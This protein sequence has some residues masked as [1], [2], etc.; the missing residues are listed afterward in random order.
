MSDDLRR[1]YLIETP[2]PE[3]L[4]PSLTNGS[5]HC[6][7][8]DKNAHDDEVQYG[9]AY[10]LARSLTSNLV[11]RHDQGDGD[12]SFLVPVGHERASRI[13]GLCTALERVLHCYDKILVAH[14]DDLIGLGLLTSLVRIVEVFL[15]YDNSCVARDVALSKTSR[16]L[17]LV[18][19]NAVDF[20]REIVSVL[21]SLMCADI[22]SDARIDA[23]CAVAS[24]MAHPRSSG[25]PHLKKELIKAAPFVIST[26]STAS[27][28]PPAEQL[29]DVSRALLQIARSSRTCLLRISSRRDTVVNMVQLMQIRATQSDVLRL[30]ALLLNCDATAKNLWSSSPSTGLLVLQA[31]AKLARTDHVQDPNKDLAISILMSVLNSDG[32]TFHHK[33]IVNHALIG[34]AHAEPNAQL[35]T[36]VASGICRYLLKKKDKVDEESKILYPTILDFLQFPINS[37]RME[38]L[39][40]LDACTSSKEAAAVLMAEY[41][42]VDSIAAFIHDSNVKRDHEEMALSILRN[43]SKDEECAK[44]IC[45]NTALLTAIVQHTIDQTFTTKSSFEFKSLEIIFNIMKSPSNRVNFK[46]F[47][48]LL[49]WLATAAAVT[50]SDGMKKKLVETILQLSQVYLQGEISNRFLV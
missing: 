38:A 2:T 31:L 28:S 19:K 16:I 8:K 30:T 46:E 45:L 6:N 18:S 33:H 41:G 3:E 1:A 43:C 40:T 13:S 39:F 29:P 11:L 26:L 17:F 25:V 12:T 10:A 50:E 9:V 42:F 47:T 22:S 34:V 24:L 23:A 5:K 44:T 36:E 21:R 20:P 4:L 35:R 37:V 49:P 27:D 7:R 14:L 32:L 48:E 15:P